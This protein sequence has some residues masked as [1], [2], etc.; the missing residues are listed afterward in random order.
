MFVKSVISNE[1]IH[2][3]SVYVATKKDFWNFWY[4]L[5][6]FFLFGWISLNTKFQLHGSPGR[7]MCER[8]GNKQFHSL[9]LTNIFRQIKPAGCFSRQC[10]FVPRNV[11]LQPK[12]HFKVALGSAEES[13]FTIYFKEHMLD[14]INSFWE[15]P[16]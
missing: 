3:K 15:I 13:V 6:Y 10:Y 7:F 5:S 1:S 9:R 12:Y 4:F 16:L 8:Q 14:Q 11:C 2:L